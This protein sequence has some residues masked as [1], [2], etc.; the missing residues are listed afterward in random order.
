MYG[1]PEPTIGVMA[2]WMG[3]ELL[4]KRIGIGYAKDLLLS[5]RMVNGDE[6]FYMGLVQ[7]LLPKDELFD[8]AYQ[9]AGMIAANAPFAVESTRR[10]LNR[11]M[12]PD[13]DEVLQ[14]T[15]AETVANLLTKDFVRGAE[16]ILAR[17][18]DQPKYER[19]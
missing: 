11:V 3:P 13:F 7:A 12:F 1:F 16:K 15:G 6:A 19:R 14:S 4:I 17:S 9:W 2:G 10:T 8:R 5:G 18:K